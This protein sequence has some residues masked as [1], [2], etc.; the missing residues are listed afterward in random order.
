MSCTRMRRRIVSVIWGSPLFQRW[1]GSPSR[2]IS[3]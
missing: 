1:T 2:S 3:L